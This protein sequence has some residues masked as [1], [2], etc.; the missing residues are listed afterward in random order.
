[1]GSLIL[2]CLDFFIPTLLVTI[3]H[4]YSAQLLFPFNN[5]LTRLD[6]H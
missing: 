3:Y 5:I 4:F 2:F 6:S 1:M